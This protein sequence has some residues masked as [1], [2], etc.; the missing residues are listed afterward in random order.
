M[1][2]KVHTGFKIRGVVYRGPDA[3]N[4]AQG[5]ARANYNQR[6]SLVHF[7]PA[8]PEQDYSTEQWNDRVSLMV[9]LIFELYW[10]HGERYMLVNAQ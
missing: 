2:A 9:E 3:K 1:S 7:R 8:M 10:R 4:K 5:T 6:N